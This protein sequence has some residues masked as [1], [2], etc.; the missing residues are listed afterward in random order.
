MRAFPTLLPVSRRGLL[1]RQQRLFDDVGPAVAT[2]R[3]GSFVDNMR[4][5]IHRWFR[6]S[7]GFSAE[8]VREL[9]AAE[10]K[11]RALHVLDPFAGSGTVILEAERCGSHG[12]GIEPHSFVA[13][14]AG[15]KLAWRPDIAEFRNL[16]KSIF[17]AARKQTGSAEGYPPL[18]GKCFPRETLERLDSL[19]QATL[20]HAEPT[21]AYELCWL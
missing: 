6:Y 7:A 15:A 3:S 20:E 2:A 8:W 21:Q 1:L 13:R 14:V 9:I 17:P 4:L 10:T 11:D 19:R 12:L 18:I 16:G 5:P